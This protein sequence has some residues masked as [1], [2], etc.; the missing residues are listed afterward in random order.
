MHG[1][2]YKTG[3]ICNKTIDEYA[4]AIDEIMSNDEL[5]TYMSSSCRN[6]ILDNYSSN[7]ICSKYIEI[8][9]SIGI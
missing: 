5:Y 4:K 2:N 8:I 6:F 1:E 9:T 3:I 7:I